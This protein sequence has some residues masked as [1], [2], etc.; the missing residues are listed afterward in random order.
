M[1]KQCCLAGANAIKEI[2]LFT[3]EFARVWAK[4]FGALHDNCSQWSSF[5]SP[6]MHRSVPA[7][8]ARAVPNSSGSDAS[9]ASELILKALP[10]RSCSKLWRGHQCSA[11]GGGHWHWLRTLQGLGIAD[12]AS[13]GLP[14][15]AARS[16]SAAHHCVSQ[17]IGDSHSHSP[18]GHRSCS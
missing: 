17:P 3:G 7:E 9:F 14:H 8:G 15:M 18:G 10:P 12:H 2:P 13:P 11:S 5:A 4:G 1:R 16:M 6:T